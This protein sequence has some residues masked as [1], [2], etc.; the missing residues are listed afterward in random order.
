MLDTNICV[1]IIKERPTPVVEKL[2][3][4]R[5]NDVGIS[6]ITAA[7]LRFGASKSRRPK[8]NHEALDLFF[9][10]LAVSPFEKAA[11]T[12]YGQIRAA[13][14]KKGRPIGPLDLLIAA[15]ALS[16]DV[17]LITNNAREFRRVPGLEV[18]SWV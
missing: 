11:A 6:A 1:Y 16:L 3:A 8:Q 4:T 9:A 10:P 14:E 5:A 15:H 18:L 13:L 17:P 2:L 12:A 7:E